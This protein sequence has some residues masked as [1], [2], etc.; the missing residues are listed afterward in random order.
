MHKQTKATNIPKS[1]KEAVAKRDC[2]NGPSTCI[3]CGL[4]GSPCAHIIRRSQGGKGIEQNIVTLCGR[5]HYSF[6]E[7]L[8]M[9]RLRPLGF[10]NR[11]EIKK[12]IIRY[13]KEFYPD[14]TPE[15]VKYHKWE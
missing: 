9:S 12:Y 4:P 13:I 6:D 7:G 2:K 3:I 10:Q 14:W 15:K 1:V 8:F 11:E 5:C